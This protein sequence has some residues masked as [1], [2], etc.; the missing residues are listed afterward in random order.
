MT[1]QSY[2]GDALIRPQ[3]LNAIDKR[4]Y[5]P[6][7]SELKARSIFTVKTDIPAGAKT[8]SYDVLTRSGAAKILAPG[9]TDVPLV[10]AD[11]TEE[12]VKIY[13][14]A[15]AFNI[16]VQEV[17]EAQ[18]AGRPIDV[19]KADTVRKAIAE[20]ENQVAFSGDKTHGIKGLTDA[21]G[22]QVYATPQNEAGTSTKW[23]DK[24]GKEI[25]ADIRKAKNLVNKLNGHEADTLLLTPDSNEELEKTFNEY[26]QQSVLE[27]IK[28]QNWFKRIETVN[29]LAKKGLAGSE[30][31]IVL[32]SSPDV[33]ELGIPLDIT[34]HPQEYAFPN[35]KVPFEERTT[36]LIIR[37][38]MAI[39]RADGI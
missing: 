13:S 3:D 32:D 23:K 36:G 38:P 1:I 16:S 11:L 20:K 14:I 35:T 24:A 21:V 25:V 15:A 12:T 10:D 27:Y 19:T 7:A 5:E 17:R 18:M 30:C 9:A 31:F 4:V 34:R 29:D 2:R 33:V 6:H 26:T 22:I 37:Y 28:S 39:C 8:Y